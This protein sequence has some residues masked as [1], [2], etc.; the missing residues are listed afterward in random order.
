MTVDE[1][2]DRVH[3]FIFWGL[4]PVGIV[5]FGAFFVRA[6]IYFLRGW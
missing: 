1:R 4:I 2:W 6:G 5:A 3:A